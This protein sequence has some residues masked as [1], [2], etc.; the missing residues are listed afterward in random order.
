MTGMIQK[1]GVVG[2]MAMAF[3]MPALAGEGKVCTKT[4]KVKAKTECATKCASKKATSLVKLEEGKAK[5]PC[6]LKAKAKGP[7]STKAKSLVSAKAKGECA[8]KCDSKKATSMVKLEEGKAKGPCTLKAKAKGPCSLK[9]KS[10]VKADGKTCPVGAAMASLPAIQYKVGK[11]VTSCSNHAAK[12]VK[13]NGGSMQYVVAG[14][15]FANEYKA[16]VAQVEATEK[17]VA[18][19]GTAYQCSASKKT[20][21]GKKAYTCNKSAGQMAAVAKAAMEKV[22]MEYKVGKKVICCNEMATDFAKSSKQKIE[23]KVGKE[24]TPCSI[25]G[26]M[27]LAKEKYRAAVKAMLQAEQAK[28]EKISKAG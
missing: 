27:N 6:T 8:T 24:V 2:M 20:F 7:C 5:G 26:R 1:I 10:M 25:T 23:Y 12:L 13:K 11:D 19:L 17:Y 15:S 4:S 22:K 16:K 18:S 9:S 21:V 28:T 3:S 14:R